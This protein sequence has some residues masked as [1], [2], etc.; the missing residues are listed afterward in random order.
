MSSSG[1]PPAK[2]PKLLAFGR[3]AHVSQSA[4]E[5]LFNEVK[6]AGLPSCF[7]RSTQRRHRDAV[8]QARTS[9]GPL[10]QKVQVRDQDAWLGPNG[11]LRL[12]SG[13]PRILQG[14][15]SRSAAEGCAPLSR[16]LMICHSRFS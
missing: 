1:G 9:F 10:L 12:A 16:P 7:S 3:R 13:F 5:C 8:A 2:K 14:H 4:L 6:A 11:E 15:A